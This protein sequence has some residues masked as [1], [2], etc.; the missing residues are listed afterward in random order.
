M[1]TRSLDALKQAVAASEVRV[2]DPYWSAEVVFDA[3]PLAAVLDHVYGKS[4]R[5]EEE[6]LFTCSDGYQPT[7]PVRRVLDHQAWIAFGRPDAPFTIYKWESGD[8]IIVELDPFYLVWENLDDEKVRNEADYGWPYQLVGIDLI[9]TR[10]RFPRMQ[11]PQVAPEAARAGFQAFRVHCSRCHKVNGEGGG[12]GPELIAGSSPL[13]YRDAAYL[14]QWIE[15]P[16]KIR[17]NSRM[18]ALNPKLPDRAGTVDA[19]LAYLTSMR[20]G[21]ED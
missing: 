14:R 21:A 10:D 2:I 8:R 4:W 7:V 11:P 5:S 15:E 17:P 1:A 18:P 19:I 3:L 20:S 13:A 9:R 16:A 12:I 6:L